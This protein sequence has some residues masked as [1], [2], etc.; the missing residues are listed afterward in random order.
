ADVAVHVGAGAANVYFIHA[1]HL[2][3]PRV[4][5]DETQK[6]VWRWDQGEPFGATPPNEDPDRDGT[7]FQFPLRFPG[8]YADRETNLAYN[9]F[10]DYSAE[11]GRYLQFDPLG[12]HDGINAY[13][14]VHL[15]PIKHSDQMGLASR[16]IC[17]TPSECPVA[18]P[19]P[20]SK[21]SNYGKWVDKCVA[22]SCQAAGYEKGSIGNWC[23]TKIEKW[24]CSRAGTNFNCCDCVKQMC[25][26]EYSANPEFW[27]RC[28]AQFLLC[29][30]RVPK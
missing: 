14:Y 11:I 2:G 6:T 21:E 16:P 1:D 22:Q 7:A 12:L 27:V 19:P 9:Y 15:S 17:E 3:T 29:M 20:P 5:A 30:G 4:I 26:N 28:D 25:R 8:Q 13:V 24:A 10:R 18:D 23:C